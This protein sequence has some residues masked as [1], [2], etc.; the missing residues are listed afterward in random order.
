LQALEDLPMSTAMRQ[1][2]EARAA[3]SIAG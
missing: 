3:M 1:E 2:F